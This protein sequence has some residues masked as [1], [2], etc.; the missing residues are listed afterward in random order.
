MLR[1]SYV[2]NGG[3]REPQH[4]AADVATLDVVS[5]GRARLGLGAGHTPAE[6]RAVGRCS[7]GWQPSADPPATSRAPAQARLCALSQLPAPR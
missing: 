7:P 2:T 4:I 3:V 1:G 6:W 5:G